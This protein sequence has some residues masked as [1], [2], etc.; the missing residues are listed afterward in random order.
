MTYR[1]VIDTNLT[2]SAFV[3]DG[4]PLQLFDQAFSRRVPILISQAMIDELEATLRKA[5]FTQYP[6][7]R[8]LTVEAI[9]LHVTA[10][11]ELVIPA[12][13][14]ASV[15]SDPKDQV[16]LASAV[17]GKASHLISGDK[18]LTLLKKYQAI[19]ILTAAEFLVLLNPSTDEPKKEQQVK[20]LS[21]PC[22]NRGEHGAALC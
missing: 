5:K 9:L 22:R 8:N 3:W 17:G 1:I 13:V 14:P 10:L 20:T 19:M 16:I 7:A 18:Y 12:P 2:I 15:I 21:P 11:T 4:L 6:K